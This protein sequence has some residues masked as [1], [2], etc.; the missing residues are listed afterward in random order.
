[1]GPFLFLSVH[2]S[3]SQKVLINTNFL[4]FFLHVLMR[5]RIV[6]HAGACDE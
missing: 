6:I 4:T 3:K 2:M 1:M 5:M